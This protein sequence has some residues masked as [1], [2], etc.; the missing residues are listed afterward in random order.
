[1]L[2][3]LCAWCLSQ[4]QFYFS[5][6]GIEYEISRISKC[7]GTEG[8]SWVA[9]DQEGGWGATAHWVSSVV[10]NVLELDRGGGYTTL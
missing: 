10:M 2:R 6:G 5:I 8:R 7:T 1:M 4:V 9:R 3:A